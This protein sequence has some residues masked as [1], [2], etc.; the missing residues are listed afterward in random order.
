ML[1]NFSLFLP[2]PATGCLSAHSARF[3]GAGQGGGRPGEKG[4]GGVREAGDE[5]ASRP[6]N[7]HYALIGTC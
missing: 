4:A 6:K 5:G 7:G 1:H 2:L 3:S